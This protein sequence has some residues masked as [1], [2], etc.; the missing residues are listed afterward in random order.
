MPTVSPFQVKCMVLEL[1]GREINQH[2][3]KCWQ[4]FRIVDKKN[5]NIEFFYVYF[6]LKMQDFSVYY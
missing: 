5:S 3:E 6:Y 2:I 1:F 4:K